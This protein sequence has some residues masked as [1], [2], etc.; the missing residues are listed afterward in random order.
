MTL[1]IWIL[2]LFLACDPLHG[3]G[4][5][6]KI[7]STNPFD[8][9]AKSLANDDSLASAEALIALLDSKNRSRSEAAVRGLLERSKREANRHRNLAIR[10]ALTA[11]DSQPSQEL[12]I[13]AYARLTELGYD[14][15]QLAPPVLLFP[16]RR[17]AESSRKFESPIFDLERLLTP[18]QRALS[19]KVYAGAPEWAH[20]QDNAYDQR[21]R[22]ILERAISDIEAMAKEG[23]LEALAGGSRALISIA[24]HALKAGDLKRARTL[25]LNIYLS[26]SP[27]RVRFE[28]LRVYC[29]SGEPE[30]VD[31]WL[32][33]IRTGNQD[34]WMA[35]ALPE[36]EAV[37]EAR[38]PRPQRD[39]K[40]KK[41][42]HR[43]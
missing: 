42:I 10:L 35:L 40:E 6:F 34:A 41:P 16:E 19:H 38:R 27:P 43:W 13:A 23:T 4:S 30:K 28:A 24:Q 12:K 20:N 21:A 29:A 31:K 26:S 7:D 32:N 14:V 39:S 5:Y 36:F 11:H 2:T 9:A 3:E 25:S 22:D 18:E 1:T 33:L 37:V 17:P 8:V 15:T